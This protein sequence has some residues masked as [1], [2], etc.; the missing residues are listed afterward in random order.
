MRPKQI[1]TSKPQESFAAFDAL[2]GRLLAV[3][4]AVVAQRITEAKASPRTGAKRG[5]KPTIKPAT[6]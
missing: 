1:Q 4:H 5:P 3:P 6:A 2:T